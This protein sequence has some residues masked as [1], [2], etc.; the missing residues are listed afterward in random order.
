MGGIGD[1]QLV[2]GHVSDTEEYREHRVRQAS[3]LLGPSGFITIEDAAVFNRQQMTAADG[4][5]ARFVKGVDG[6]PEDAT[7]NDEIGNTV[8]WAYYRE[9]MGFDH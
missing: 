5:L 1:V 9:V 2:H 4:T 3:N 6:R 7:Q 8:G